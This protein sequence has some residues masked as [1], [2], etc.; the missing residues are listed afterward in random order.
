MRCEGSVCA[1][2]EC[3][4]EYNCSIVDA[5]DTRR[6]RVVRA[7][8]WQNQKQ[9]YLSMSIGEEEEAASLV[10]TER[11]LEAPARIVVVGACMRVRIN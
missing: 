8:T 5:R 2:I 11:R 6:N 10:K 1:S 7:Q 4:H 3:T 9:Q